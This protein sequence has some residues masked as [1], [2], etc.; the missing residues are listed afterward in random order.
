MKTERVRVFRKGTYH[1]TQY[2]PFHLRFAALPE[3][4]QLKVGDI[5]YQGDIFWCWNGTEAHQ[6]W[7]GIQPSKKT[8][9]MYREAVEAEEQLARAK[10][11]WGDA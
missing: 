6:E 3:M 4:L 11:E 7:T 8:M 5:V 9:D 2:V 10:T 1:S